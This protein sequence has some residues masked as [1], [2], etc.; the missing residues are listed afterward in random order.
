MTDKPLSDQL[1]TTGEATSLLKV[2]RGKPITVIGNAAVRA[3]FDD[4][5]LQQAKNARSAPG[6]AEVVLNPD[7]HR[8]Y[9]APIGCVVASPSHIYPGPVGVDIKCSMSLLQLDP[10]A[11]AVVGRRDRR[12]LIDAVLERVPRAPAAASVTRRRRATST[13][14]SAAGW[15]SRAR[16]AACASPSASRRRGPTTARTLSTSATTTPRTPWRRGSIA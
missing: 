15:P 7:A 2:E 14:S 8:G 9:G 1:V 16:R 12:A 4:V 10:A 13:P 3:T 5:T 11:D 6:V